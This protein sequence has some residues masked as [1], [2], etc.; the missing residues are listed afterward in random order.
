[1]KNEYRTLRRSPSG[2]GRDS[3]ACTERFENAGTAGFEMG[4]M[5]QN[6]KTAWILRAKLETEKAKTC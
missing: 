5:G 2:G 4:L 6:E 3:Q 1:M